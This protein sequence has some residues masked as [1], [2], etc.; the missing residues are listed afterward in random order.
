MTAYTN[1]KRDLPFGHSAA[2]QD[3]EVLLFLN[4]ID[5]NLNNTLSDLRV[6]DDFCVGFRQWILA[7]TNHTLLGL[8]DFKFSAYSQGTSEAFDKF[9]MKN[10]TRRFR[11][12][13]AEYMYHQLAWRNAWPNWMHLEDG[14]LGTNDAVVISIPFADTGDKHHLHDELL[15][16]CD[17]LGIPVLV[18]CAYFAISSG[19]TMDFTHTCITDVTFSLSKAFPVAHAR[20][21]IRLTRTDDDDTLF[22]YQKSY[23]NNRLGAKIGLE[24]IN[25]FKPDYIPTKYKQKQIEFC[26]ELSIVPSKTVM[27]G[28]AQSNWKEYNRG[29]VTNR[30]SIHR[31][32]DKDITEL[33]GVINGCK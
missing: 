9:Y 22:V 8:E 11:C 3:P 19:I 5:L 25:N 15:N 21:G 30:L 29:G 4:S 14:I 13:K 24:L 33:K 10:R 28:I 7:S 16:Q 27:F 23:Y 1:D 12:F 32:L 18:D 17:K 26:K 20:I 31:F 6:V 2:I